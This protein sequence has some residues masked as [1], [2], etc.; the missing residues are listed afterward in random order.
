MNIATFMSFV[1]VLFESDCDYYKSLR[2]I[3][4]TLELKEVYALKAKF[5]PEH[6]RCITWAILDDGRAF[7]DDVKTTIDFTGPDMSFPQSYLIDIL[8]NIRYAIPVERASFP[9][10]WRR[11]DRPKEDQS[12][13]T[14][15]GQGGKQRDTP[16]TRGGYGRG[17]GGGNNRQNTYGQGGFGGG[18]GFPPYAGHGND[19]F[20]NR[21]MGNH[22]QERPP[23]QGTAGRRDWRAGWTDFCHPKI[24]VLMDPYLNRNDGR[25]CL[26]DV[27]DAGGLRQQ[28]LPTL[29]RF[30]WPNG[31]S[32]LC[33][34][35]T[36]GRCMFPECRFQRYGGHPGPNDIPDEF[37]DNVVGKLTK[38]IQA[39]MQLG[40]DDGSLAKKTKQ[41]P[42]N[43]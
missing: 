32:F 1:W 11:K 30:C 6:C 33:W 18:Q 35:S 36:L 26:G 13:R 31:R 38:G 29:P 24:K 4:K 34:S 9:D 12:R 20:G 7:F 23:Y 37:A 17:D 19:S 15:G 22:L 16:S 10:K 21:G 5:T 28:D 27:L 42:S 41:E 2:Q 3:Y 25:L 8:N 14:P 43:P 40:G 39:R